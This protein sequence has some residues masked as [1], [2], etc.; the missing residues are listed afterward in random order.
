[1][2]DE[3]STNQESNIY[4]PSVLGLLLVLIAAAVVW[5]GQVSPSVAEQAAP[6]PAVAPTQAE[7]APVQVSVGDSSAGQTL[8]SQTCSAC[9]GP[10]GEGIQ[11]LGKDLTTSEFVTGQ[12]D[13]DLTAFIKVGRGP[14]DPL[15]T[16]GIAMP[17]KGGNPALNDEDLQN[18]VAY[19]RTLH[20]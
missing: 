7:P 16:T 18:I 4:L 20:K 15:N 10:A 5:V 1:M 12:T 2:T 13:T 6:E 14:T 8:F 3:K 19:L 11:G 9:H 17:P